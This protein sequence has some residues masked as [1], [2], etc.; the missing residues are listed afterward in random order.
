MYTV[1]YSI[2]QYS[3]DLFANESINVGIAFY[4]KERNERYF[5]I[6]QRKSRLFSF[7]DELDRE[8]TTA[9]LNGIKDDWINTNSV[10]DSHKNLQSF[11][12]YYVNEFHF[13]SIKVQSNVKDLDTYLDHTKRYF[14]GL[15]MDKSNRLSK[16]ESLM[17]ISNYFKKDMFP[18]IPNHVEKGRLGDPM[19]FDLF[20]NSP[21]DVS[22]GIKLL[23]NHSHSTTHLRSWL[24]FAS[25]NPHVKLV[26]MLENAREEIIEPLKTMLKNAELNKEITVMT[27]E[28]IDQLS[29]L[30]TTY[31]E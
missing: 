29:E 15:S 9:T 20:A 30:A 7:D 1:E 18:S 16:Q 13:S 12:K 11:I 27:V 14:L 2:L 8:F 6:M 4:V 3:P 10:F 23:K 19:H 25:T 17:Y 28:D 21:R 22:V 31:H 5:E 26:I 24:Y